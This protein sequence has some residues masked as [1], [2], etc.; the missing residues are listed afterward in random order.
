LGTPHTQAHEEENYL[1]HLTRKMR[2]DK[3]DL[4]KFKTDWW[5]PKQED[6]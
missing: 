6:R 1:S 3:N 4:N 2:D 5:I